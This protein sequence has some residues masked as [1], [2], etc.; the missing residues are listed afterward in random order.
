VS[1][2]LLCVV[3]KAQQLTPS[4]FHLLCI[5]SSR[6]FVA[7]KQFP[8]ERW[9]AWR[10]NRRCDVI[11]WNVLFV[12]RHRFHDS[13][14]WINSQLWALWL[15]SCDLL[16]QQYHFTCSLLFYRRLL[17]SYVLATGGA[18]ATAL[19]LNALTKVLACLIFCTTSAIYCF[20]WRWP[21]TKLKR[22]TK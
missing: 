14:A 3:V 1:C 9:P 17:T 6:W 15:S 4:L 19:S 7:S 5:V 10:W 13:L 2:T 21:V 18:V 11:E 22:Q 8:V 12:W 20:F 16:Y